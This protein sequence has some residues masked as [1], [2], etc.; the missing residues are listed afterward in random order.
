MQQYVMQR[1]T[2]WAI[3]C[4]ARVHEGG[5]PVGPARLRSWWGPMVLSPN[6]G[7]DSSAQHSGRALR[8]NDAAA[9]ETDACVRAL[10]DDLRQAVVLAYLCG[11][12]M[13]DK[14]SKAGISRRAFYY[15]L[16]RAYGELLGLLNDQA[17][18][19]TPLHSLAQNC[20]TL[21]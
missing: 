13:D 7:S 16:D 12:S 3:W 1:L 10:S 6:A 11:G 9:Q 8:V 19:L 14:A 15:R 5:A 4:L 20:A 18:G 21:V 17:A 2:L